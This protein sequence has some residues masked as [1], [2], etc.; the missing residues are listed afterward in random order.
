MTHTSISS[1]TG[2]FRSLLALGCS[3]HPTCTTDHIDICFPTCQPLLTT[4][5]VSSAFYNSSP[6]FPLL[7]SYCALEAYDFRSF[8]HDLIH[9]FP[10]CFSQPLSKLLLLSTLM[11]CLFLPFLHLASSVVSSPPPSCFYSVF[12]AFTLKSC[13]HKVVW[14]LSSHLAYDAVLHVCLLVAAL[15]AHQGDFQLAEGFGQDVALGEELPPLYNV[16][17]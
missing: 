13:G 12:S 5:F 11:F 17:F 2:G 16:S 9:L 3:L 14:G 10:S 8:T 6:L 4:L 7:S 15:F 1:L